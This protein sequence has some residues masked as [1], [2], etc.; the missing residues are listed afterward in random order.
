MPNIEYR[1]HCRLS[2]SQSPVELHAQVGIYL[3]AYR[4]TLGVENTDGKLWQSYMVTAVLPES[5]AMHDL[6][7]Q[8]AQHVKD[9]FS[10][11]EVSV[12][13]QAGSVDTL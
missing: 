12:V 9:Y 8:M 7:W 10:L 13:T 5:D 3:S 2:E 11:S 4:V 6:F 1:M